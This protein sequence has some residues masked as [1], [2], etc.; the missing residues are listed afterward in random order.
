MPEFKEIPSL[1]ESYPGIDE[2]EHGL[3]IEFQNNV[4]SMIMDGRVV[5]QSRDGELLG[6]EAMYESIFVDNWI[7]QFAINEVNGKRYFDL[8]AWSNITDKFTKGVIVVED[9]TNIPMFIIPSFIRPNLNTE[10]GSALAYHAGQ[11]SQAKYVLDENRK[12]QIINGLAHKVKEILPTSDKGHNDYTT[13]VPDWVYARHAIVPMAMKAM[14]YIRDVYHKELNDDEFNHAEDI[15]KRFYTGQIVTPNEKN[16]ILSLTNNE[17]SF[18]SVIKD[19]DL[20]ENNKNV[21]D[22]SSDV[23]EESAFDD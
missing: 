16:I 4:K 1:K 8:Q 13:M 6:Y 17:F 5:L 18:N 19:G 21:S 3:I 10:E 9:K 11:A 20:Q 15:L 22:K 14:M 2:I 7:G 23:I 12:T